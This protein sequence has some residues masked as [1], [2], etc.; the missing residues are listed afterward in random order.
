MARMVF[1]TNMKQIFMELAIQIESTLSSKLVEKALIIDPL[2]RSR[3]P[4]SESY[5]L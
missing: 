5:Q 1:G 2:V 4:E 3:L